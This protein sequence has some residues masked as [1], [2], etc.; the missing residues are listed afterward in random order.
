MNNQTRMTLTQ[1]GNP[2]KILLGGPLMAKVTSIT[3][4]LING[5]T[6]VAIG[7]AN[8]NDMGSFQVDET[9]VQ[10][11]HAVIHAKKVTQRRS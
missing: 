2:I 5:K 4:N 3:P 8:F 9:P 6:E 7:T 10:I 11:A 1:D